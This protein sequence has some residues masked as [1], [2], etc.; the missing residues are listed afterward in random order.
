M[1]ASVPQAM[2]EILA[3]A[4]VLVFGFTFGDS[5]MANITHFHLR[6]RGSRTG[7]PRP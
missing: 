7:V 5:P 1:H 4:T 3:L 2:S 6:M